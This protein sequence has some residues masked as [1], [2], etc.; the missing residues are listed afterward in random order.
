MRIWEKIWEKGHFSRLLQCE[1]T[2]GQ[3]HVGAGAITMT[4][5]EGDS[6]VVGVIGGNVLMQRVELG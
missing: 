4:G 2:S 6:G 5:K 3:V 1:L